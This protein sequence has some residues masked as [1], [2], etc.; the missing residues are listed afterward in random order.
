MRAERWPISDSIASA[1]MPDRVAAPVLGGAGDVTD[2]DLLR[3]ERVAVG[4]V[5]WCPGYPLAST[6]AD[7]LADDVHSPEPIARRS[8]HLRESGAFGDRAAAHRFNGPMGIPLAWKDTAGGRE[9]SSGSG[10]QR[11]VIS[12]REHDET[13]WVLT[14]FGTLTDLE[15][16][17][18]SYFYESE[19][20]AID[21][22][23]QLSD[24]PPF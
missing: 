17:N 1:A 19:D 11:F 21:S 15:E 24:Q 8:G 5:C 14:H 4:A 6:V 16:R 20:E 23:Q 10:R 3:A 12:E 13:P 9:A 18:G 22:A 7:Q 2:Q